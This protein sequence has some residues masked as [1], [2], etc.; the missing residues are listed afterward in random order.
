MMLPIHRVAVVST[1]AVF[2]SLA[3]SSLWAATGRVELEVVAD[4]RGGAAL[5]FQEWMQSAHPRRREERPPPHAQPGDEVKIDVRG[6]ADS[7]VYAVT[8]LIVGNELI[9]P[10]ARFKRSEAGKLARWLDDLAEHGPPNRREARPAF[11]LTAKQLEQVRD[12][13]SQT[14]GI[15]DQGHDAKRGR[16]EDRPR[17]ETPDPTD[18]KPRPDERRQDRRGPVGPVVRHGA[19]LRL[20]SAG[21]LHGAAAEG[22]ESGV[23]G[24]QGQVG[25]GGLAHRLA[26]GEAAG[27]GAAGH[28][29]VPQRQRAE[30]VGRQDAGRDQRAVKAPV[31]LD[32]NA[33]ARHGI[34]PAKAMVSMP[35]A[36]RPTAWRCGS[37][38]SRPG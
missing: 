27:R 23:R 6:T 38:C 26:A 3:V 32:H 16:R 21:L 34:D 20:A 33:L 18:R 8:G 28:V 19:G 2:L 36:G 9:V 22:Q 35:R 37:C 15:L 4:A 30:R 14:G 24:R 25:P 1:L 29:R 13:L 7:P 17:L 11:G 12:D 31:L 5:D 10:G